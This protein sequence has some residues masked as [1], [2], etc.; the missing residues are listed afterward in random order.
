MAR[1]V[2]P[3]IREIAE[4]AMR[5]AQAE[6]LTVKVAQD[7]ALMSYTTETAPVVESMKKLAAA[8]REHTDDITYR[9]VLEYIYASR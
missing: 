7:K 5:R 8:C 1:T 6:R 4:D 2:Y 9:D 3:S